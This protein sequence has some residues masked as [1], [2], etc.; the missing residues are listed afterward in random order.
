MSDKKHNCSILVNSCD[1]YEVAWDPFFKLLKEQWPDC[2]FDIYLLT[3]TKD[4]ECQYFPVKVIKTGARWP[5]GKMVKY[6]VKRIPTEFVIYLLDDEFLASPVNSEALDKVLCYMKEHNDVG[7]VMLRHTPQQK[8]DI[9][10][11][12]F[13]RD[14][15]LQDN[16]R[17]VGISTLYRKKYFLKLLRVHENPWEYE[18]YASIRSRRYPEKVMQYNKSQPVIF[19]YDDSPVSGWGFTRGKWIKGTKELFEKHHI[20]VDFS[21]LGWYEPDYSDYEKYA[22]QHNLELDKILPAGMTENKQSTISM[23]NLNICNPIQILKK[24]YVAIMD[25]IRIIKSLI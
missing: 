3:E 15:V 13:E 14:K 25:K 21:K 19:D 16:F 2:P 22:W 17:I 18:Y 4:Y 6:A 7:V 20:T 1:K 11:P 10:E 9:P 5:W 12:L 23:R 8:V 24:F